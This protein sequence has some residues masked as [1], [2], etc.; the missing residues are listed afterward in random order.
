MSINRSKW[1]DGSNSLP[2]NDLGMTPNVNSYP[3]GNENEAEPQSSP[4]TFY[5]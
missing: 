2:D 5:R 3:L 1:E 4:E